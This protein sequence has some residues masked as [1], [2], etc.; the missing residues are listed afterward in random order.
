MPSDVLSLIYSVSP[1]V[2]SHPTT[3]DTTTSPNVTTEVPTQPPP[4]QDNED[5]AVTVVLTNF[6]ANQV[7]YNFLIPITLSLIS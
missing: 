5:N 6:Q 4:T 3:V 7:C 2:I 1:N